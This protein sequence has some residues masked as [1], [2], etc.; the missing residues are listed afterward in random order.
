M[1][2]YRLT[3]PVRVAGFTASNRRGLLARRS[4]CPLLSVSRLLSNILIGVRIAGSGAG[5]HE[6]RSQRPQAICLA[7]GVKRCIA[8]RRRDLIEKEVV[9]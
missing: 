9:P 8:T 5:G 6:G 3:H 4:D 2:R 1:D 7:R